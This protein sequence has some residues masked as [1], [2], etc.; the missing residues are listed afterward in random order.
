MAGS[1][2]PLKQ[3]I[4]DTIPIDEDDDATIQDVLQSINDSTENNIDVD[5]IDDDSTPLLN[6]NTPIFDADVDVDD[7]TTI[8]IPKKKESFTVDEN[9]TNIKNDLVQ[10]AID[11]VILIVIF[12]II[13]KIPL[14]KLVFKYIAL[15]K[16]PMGDVIIKSGIGALIFLILQKIIKKYI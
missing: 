15:N 2:T 12:T 7:D 1:S 13:M 8:V 16:V 5:S 6:T 11:Y 4:E 3:I 14:E 10:F 9:K